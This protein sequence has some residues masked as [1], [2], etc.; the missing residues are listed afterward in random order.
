MK[1]I[2]LSDFKGISSLEVAQLVN[3]LTAGGYIC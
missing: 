2:N 3:Q 1:N